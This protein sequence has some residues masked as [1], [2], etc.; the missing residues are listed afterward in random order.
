[1]SIVFDSTAGDQAIVISHASELSVNPGTT[2]MTIAC[3][4]KC[5]V[6]TIGTIVSKRSTSS[7]G[8]Q[9]GV[10]TYS[11]IEKLFTRFGGVLNLTSTSAADD[12]AWHSAVFVNRDV[13]G[14]YR[15][16]IYQDGVLVSSSGA[17]PASGNA[18]NTMDVLINARRDVDN[19]DFAFVGDFTTSDVRIYDGVAFTAEEAAS[20]HARNGNDTLFGGLVGRWK[21]KEGH[22]TETVSGSGSVKD[23]TPNANNGTPNSTPD[24]DEDA[25]R[26]RRRRA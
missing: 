2:E 25:V 3:W 17:A 10:T 5:P 1:M 14:V 9:V 8:F 13:S 15:S 21:L 7:A 26:L 19:T 4:F 24:Y 18:T 12:G 20:F 23:W 6:N 16:F 11:G 22:P